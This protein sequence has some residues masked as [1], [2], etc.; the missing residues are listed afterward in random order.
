VVLVKPSAAGYAREVVEALRKSGFD[1][2]YEPL[3]EER[4]AV[5][6]EGGDP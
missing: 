1:V 2:G 3:E 6:A 5:W 4:T